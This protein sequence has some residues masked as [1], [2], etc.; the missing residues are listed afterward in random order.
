MRLVRDGSGWNPM[1]RGGSVLLI[2][3]FAGMVCLPC[4]GQDTSD[5][6]NVLV[7]MVDDL[8]DWVEPLG[9]HPQVQ[10]PNLNQ[11]AESAVN[12][13]NAH[14]QSPVCNPSRTSFLTG[15]RPSTT[16][17]YGLSTWF[18]SLEDYEDW[19]TLPQYF[20]D[21]GYYT[22]TTGKVYHGRYPPSG[23]RKAGVEFSEWGY[24]GNQGPY[25]DQPYVPETGHKLVDWGP[26]PENNSQM[27]DWKVAQWAIKHL[28]N[29]PEDKP[30][31]LTVGFRS[32][33]VPL[34]AP[35]EWFDRYPMDQLNLPTVR[36]DDRE[37]IPRFAW[38]L[39]WHL[40][41]PRLA[42]LQM[43][44]EWQRK[45]RAYLATVSF[46]DMLVGR[47]MQTLKKENLRENTIVVFMSD[48]G[49]HLGTKNISGK[50]T[51]WH[52]STR[53][54]YIFSVPGMT[55]SGWDSDQPVEVLDLYPTLIDLAGLP[56]KDG[57][58]G[59]SL[60]PL[61][62]NPDRER[63]QP[64][65][66]THGPNN[67][68]VVTEKWRY[69]RYANGSEELY[70]R[71][72][73]PYEWTNLAGKEKYSEVV[74]RLSKH[75]PRNDAPPAPGDTSRLIEIRDGTPYWEGKPIQKDDPVPMEYRN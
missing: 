49:Y 24:H 30:F 51:L 19:T 64:A 4:S 54:P 9:G 71:G 22:M 44:R 1:Q 70:N 25:R 66:T 59:Q 56:A 46:M 8:N 45:V 43:N 31:F 36:G 52:E 2:L 26:F 39:H 13:T 62:K 67:H 58:D 27:E 69:I 18:R 55:E 41:E 74:E 20:Q 61:L 60:V 63:E 11:L 53:V 28:K 23:R 12:F 7:L 15:L 50:N 72:E 35:Q 10:T 14:V 21:H 68:V 47:V 75:L 29:P 40:P 48:H 3:F 73:D 34:Y 32:P 6:P 57:L 37:D 17:V 5:R 38:Y 65:I 33:H 42:W 16:G